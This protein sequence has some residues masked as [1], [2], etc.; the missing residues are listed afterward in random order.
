MKIL[1]FDIGNT[2]A[3][4]A[5]YESGRV[6]SFGSVKNDRIPKY[7]YKIAN[8]GTKSQL[9]V[10]VCSVV[11]KLTSKL[12]M[13][14]NRLNNIKIWV[15]GKNLPVK[16]RHKYLNGNKLGIDR[17]VN[18][19]GAIRIYKPPI[20]IFDFGTAIT[21]D[22]ISTKGIFEGGMIIPGPKISFN[23]L[24]EKTALIPKNLPF[25]RQSKGL[26]GRSTYDG[27]SAGILEGWGALAD[28]LVHRFKQESGH[29]PRVIA[30][31]GYA[32][33][34]KPYMHKID[35]VDPRHSM[36]SLLILFKDFVTGK[37]VR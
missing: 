17:L 34:L 27:L 2:A 15:A 12:C 37:K 33:T 9:N 1:L 4:Y 29:N 25:P 11:P 21:V 5:I 7:A 3:T 18:A 26:I 14:I 28:G 35:I 6:L 24:L 8:S 36:K 16:V 22:Y 19:Y 10:V 20:V 32:E 23:A 13:S 30:T 31:G